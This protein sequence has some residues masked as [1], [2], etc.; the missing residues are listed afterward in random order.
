MPEIKIDNFT[1]YKLIKCQIGK[2]F[3]F[4]IFHFLKIILMK[5][6]HYKNYLYL[7]SLF[8]RFSRKYRI[9]NT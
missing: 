7:F 2:I 1:L 6:N 4:K 5:Y 9:I 8:S 3:F